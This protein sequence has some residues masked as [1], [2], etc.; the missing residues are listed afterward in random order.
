M[1]LRAVPGGIPGY[2]NHL[3]ITGNL[4]PRIGYESFQWLDNVT[5][6]ILSNNSITE[7]ASHTFSSLTMLRSLDLNDNQLTLIHPEA[8]MVP[9]SPLEELNL[10]NSLFNHNSLIDLITA[11][12]WGGLRSLRRL[13]LSDNS[14]LLLPPGM[15]SPLP[16]LRQLRLD[17]NSLVAVYNGTFSGVELLEELDLTGNRFT[18]FSAEGLHELERLDRA[19]LLLGYNPYLC[20]CETEEFANWVNNSKVRVGDPEKLRC[21]S[22]GQLRHVAVQVLSTKVLHC[23]QRDGMM[24][25]EVDGLSLQTS[26][27]LLGL[28]CGFVGMVF[29]FVVFLNRRGIEKWV[30]EMRDGC[31]DM[32]E[33]YQYRYEI[34]SDPRI[35]QIGT[36]GKLEQ[37]NKLEAGRQIPNKTSLSQIPADIA[38]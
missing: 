24:V 21:A 1:D 5:N 36:N 35:R 25:E 33:G 31:Q 22:P 8:F 20:A 11:L 29:C 30:V 12:R 6:L 23:N 37:T 4:I 18:A 34:D 2:T 16:N 32:M 10:S 19:R 38:I 17:N 9:G 28:V 3:V 15:F 7:I 13:D 14:L 27:V 26:Y